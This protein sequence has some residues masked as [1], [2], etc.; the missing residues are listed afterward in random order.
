MRSLRWIVGGL[1]AVFLLVGIVR[2]VMHLDGLR[3]PLLTYF[4]D[5]PLSLHPEPPWYFEP[6]GTLAR[7]VKERTGLKLAALWTCDVATCGYSGRFAL[8]TFPAEDDGRV[9]FDTRIAGK[10]GT[11]LSEPDLRVPSQADYDD[12]TL[13]G[14]FGQEGTFIALQLSGSAQSAEQMASEAIARWRGNWEQCRAEKRCPPKES[15]G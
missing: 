2:Q 11:L 10:I 13:Q 4:A 9:S 15:H 7:K 1:V 8:I 3:R 14:V 12:A 6:D 5:H